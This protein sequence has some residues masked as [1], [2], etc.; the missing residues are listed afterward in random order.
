MTCPAARPKPRESETRVT[1]QPED[2][3]VTHAAPRNRE[4]YGNTTRTARKYSHVCRTDSSGCT[5]KKTTGKL[6]D[7]HAH[8][9][10]AIHTDIHNLNAEEMNNKAKS[11]QPGVHEVHPYVY[12][13]VLRGIFFLPPTRARLYQG[14]AILS[15]QQ[16][17]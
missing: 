10:Y 8:T 12:V 2:G 5:P 13:L 17:G 4:I 7:L 11:N 3:E 9:E 6:A 14:M 1:T 16:V 15:Q